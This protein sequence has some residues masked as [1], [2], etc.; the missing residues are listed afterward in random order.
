MYT[1]YYGNSL[2]SPK[3]T[4]K[5]NIKIV[6]VELFELVHLQAAGEMEQRH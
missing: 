2:S 1:V 3:T 6:M 4:I 5:M